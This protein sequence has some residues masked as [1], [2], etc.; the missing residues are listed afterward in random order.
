MC[1]SHSAAG[2]GVHGPLL[3]H[4]PYRAAT[5][6]W[7]L[8]AIGPLRGCLAC[9]APRLRL[10]GAAC[11]QDHRGNRVDGPRDTGVDVASVLK[12]PRGG[13]APSCWKVAAVP[14]G[15]PSR[16]PWA[17]FFAFCVRM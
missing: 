4:H 13:D 15:F 11:S 10:R 9:L 1:G 6:R 3:G 7:E 17:G 14:A 16:Q 5:S 2:A 12:E 8:T